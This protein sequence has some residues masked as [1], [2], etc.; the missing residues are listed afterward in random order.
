MWSQMADIFLSYS[1]LDRAAMLQVAEAIRR[2]GYAPWWD[3]EIPAHVAYGDLIA[4]KIRA[5][6]ATIVLWSTSAVTSE[7]VR[8]ESE[9][10]RGAR[11]LIQ[12]SL[13]GSTP[14]L[15][16]NLLQAAPLQGWNGDPD[17]P[18]WR[19]IRSSLRTLC[20]SPQERQQ[21]MAPP[22][23]APGA[24]KAGFSIW[25]LIG[26]G[27]VL[28][29]AFAI[30]ALRREQPV[31]FVL[32]TAPTLNAPQPSADKPASGDLDGQWSV[33]WTSRGR[34]HSAVLSVT[35]TSAVLNV[36]VLSENLRVRESCTM[37]P[38]GEGA[39][40]QCRD[41]VVM[42]GTGAY[43]PDAFLLPRTTG[44]LIGGRVVGAPEGPEALATFA[45]R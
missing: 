37:S 33:M 13:D 35:G 8:A 27:A 19:Q 36:S 41:P 30:F 29:A 1:R 18:G 42:S 10:A 40:I 12:A 20:G 9:A 2:E 38:Q 6:K 39:S 5:S 32:P 15:P 34:L 43:R 21:T 3:D 31:P 17:H 22:R 25:W 44:N 7:W 16:F 26:I 4:E 28:V 23:P 11:K 45:R 14:P 24:A